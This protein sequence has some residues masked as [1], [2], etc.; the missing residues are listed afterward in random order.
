MIHLKKITVKDPSFYPGAHV[1]EKG[2]SFECTDVNLLVGGQGTGKSTLINLLA[3]NDRK[4]L[5]ISSAKHVKENGI[6]SFHFDT[7][8]HNPRTRDAEYYTDI[9]GNDIGIGFRDASMSRWKS[10]GEILE[11]MVLEPL[12][13]AKDCVILLDEPESGLSIFNQFRLIA[14]IETAV[15]NN[16]QLFIATHCYPVIEAYE[17]ISLDHMC[18][19]PGKDYIG[20]FR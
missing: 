13:T 11:D 2:F 12:F 15:K 19:M 9:H 17:V 14:G 18:R 1:F 5:A 20:A 10:H 16:C 8:K 7:E 6:Q 3:K 4:C